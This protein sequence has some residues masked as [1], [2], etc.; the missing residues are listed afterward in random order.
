[1]PLTKVPKPPPPSRLVGMT[2]SVWLV[3]G[4][5]LVIGALAL[6]SVV[7]LRSTRHATLDL[8]RM[9]QQFEPLSRSVRDLGDGLA[10][11]DRAV[12]AYL[13]ADTQDNRAAAVVAAEHLSRTA[14]RI[15][16]TDVDDQ[17][18]PVA[19]VL[20]RITAHQAEGFLLLNLQDRRRDAMAGLEQAFAALD[21]RLTSAGGAGLMVGDNIMARPSLAELARALEQARLERTH[22]R[23]LRCR[24]AQPRRG[25]TAAH[26]RGPPRG[27]AGLTR[28]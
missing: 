18:S 5:A 15:V 26:P 4:F 28:P 17:A 16:D 1:V 21:R 8:A 23:R 6:A 2:I 22:P 11:F 12:L 7:T 25:A 27:T 13:R 19:T 9:Q 24:R 20:Q 14:N 3:L 10:T